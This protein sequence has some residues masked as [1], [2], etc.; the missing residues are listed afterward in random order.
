MPLDAT[1]A[2]VPGTNL[3]QPFTP[4]QL[5]QSAA[6][7]AILRGAAPAPQGVRPGKRFFQLAQSLS[8]TP[9]AG[10]ALVLTPQPV[11]VGL[12][13]KYYAEIIITISNPSAGSALTRTPFGPF[14][15]LSGI[16]YTDP[17]Q[18]NRIS[19]TGWHLASVCA[20]RRKRVPGAALTTDSPSGFGATL[21]PIAAPSSIAANSNGTVRVIYEIPLSVGRNSLRGGVVAGTVFS[22]QQV[23]LT[24]NPNLVA[25]GTDPLAAVYTGAAA[26]PNQPTMTG[27]LNF[28][29]EYWDQYSKSLLNPLAPDLST[30]YELKSSL[31]TPLVAGQD[32]YFRYNPLREYWSTVM[33]FDN[34]GVM[35]PGTDVNYFKLQAANQTTFWQRSPNVQSYMTRNAIGDDP[36][37]GV[38]LFD[39]TDDPIVTAADGNTVLIL[40]PSSVTSGA[41]VTIGWEDIGIASVLAT[42]PTLAGQAGVG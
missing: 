22:N 11:P 19:T 3:L 5:Q 29:Q 14:N 27:T 38:Y 16:S 23:Q 17:T 12:V 4:Q 33:A 35:N 34:A 26:A 15:V 28:Y 37:A 24:I 7:S 40:N 2:A 42:A 10:Q 30:I 21:S 41:S 18:T 13:T 36:P 20:M 8:F 39:T 9:I 1:G 31:F 25:T 32:N 6:A